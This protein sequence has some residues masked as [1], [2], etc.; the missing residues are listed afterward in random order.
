MK[1]FWKRI[2]LQLEDAVVPGKTNPMNQSFVCTYLHMYKDGE[3]EEGVAL[4]E[5]EEADNQEMLKSGV[6]MSA[7][8]RRCHPS[9][10]RCHSCHDLSTGRLAPVLRVYTF[11]LT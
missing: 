6:V 7:T 5:L 1:A 3:E 9:Q 10:E 2:Q 4:C 8:E 11:D